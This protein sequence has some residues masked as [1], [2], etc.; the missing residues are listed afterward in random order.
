[1]KPF[2]VPRGLPAEIRRALRLKRPGTFL[3]TRKALQLADLLGLREKGLAK[4]HARVSRALARVKTPKARAKWIGQLRDAQGKFASV[5]DQ[6]AML[7]AQGGVQPLPPLASGDVRPIIE[8]PKALPEAPL[9]PVMARE[10]EIGV[11]YTEAAGYKHPKGASSDVSFNAR[12][13]RRGGKMLSEEDVREA[14][15]RF[16][17]YGDFPEDITARTVR[18]EDWRGR[19]RTGQAHE[20][21]NFRNILDAVGDEGV[22]VGAVK[23]EK[24]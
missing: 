3:S 14:M 2:R 11:D 18:W 4:E 15:D 1:V 9:V 8:P 16:A 13:F 6:L 5:R 12:L 19:E 21:Q 22:R 20:L 23:P 17:G 7:S 24:L 10:W